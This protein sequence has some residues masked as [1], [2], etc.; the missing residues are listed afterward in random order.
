MELEDSPDSPV[1]AK[2]KPSEFPF[3][4]PFECP[5]CPKTFKK[6]RK[7]QHHIICVHKCQDI[8]KDVKIDSGSHCDDFVFVDYAKKNIKQET[9]ALDQC[10]KCD[11][12]RPTRIKI[13]KNRLGWVRLNGAVIG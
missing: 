2:S 10:S 5:K 13:D 8:L 1:R 4:P 11:E 9:V 7:L 12:F 6:K 3:G